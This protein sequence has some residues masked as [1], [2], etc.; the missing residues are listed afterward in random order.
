MDV[1]KVRYYTVGFMHS[2]PSFS[3]AVCSKRLHPSS[4]VVIMYLYGNQRCFA[5]P[6]E[7]R[8]DEAGVRV[9]VYTQ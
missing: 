2:F 6:L 7:Y 9:S 5:R 8:L 1:S 3:G 4:Y